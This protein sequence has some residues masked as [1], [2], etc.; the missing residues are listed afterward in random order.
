MHL[1]VGGNK[2]TGGAQRGTGTNQV[3][4]FNKSMDA[5]VAL[6]VR[7][8]AFPTESQRGRTFLGSFYVGKGMPVYSSYPSAR[9]RFWTVGLV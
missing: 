2:N 4:S 5:D 7:L 9:L 6:P 3:Q 8:F 1:S